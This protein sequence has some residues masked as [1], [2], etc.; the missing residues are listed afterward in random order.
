MTSQN[1][2]NTPPENQAG[3][4][5]KRIVETVSTVTADGHLIELVYDPIKQRAQ[6]AHWDGHRVHLVSSYAAD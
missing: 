1:Q 3:P 5:A 4:Q 2:S 6:L